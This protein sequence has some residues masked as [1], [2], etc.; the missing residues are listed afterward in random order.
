M[1]AVCGLAC[2][3]CPRLEKGICLC[4]GVGGCMAGTDPRAPDKLEGFA[5]KIGYSCPIL[6]CAIEK[7]VDYCFRCEE[8]PCETHDGYIYH[9]SFLDWARKNKP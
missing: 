2:E 7:G 1:P 8:F 6:K 3:I 4:G 5:A 9:E